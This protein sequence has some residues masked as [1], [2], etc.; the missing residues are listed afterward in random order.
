M[1]DR[2]PR[3]D[4]KIFGDIP[5]VLVGKMWK[6]RLE[7]RMDGVHAMMEHGIHSSSTEGAYSVV[8]SAGYKDDKDSGITFTY[9]GSGGKSSEDEPASRSNISGPQCSDQTVENRSNKALLI[10]VKTRRAVRVVRGPNPNSPWAPVKGYRY[11]GL[12]LV[13][14][15]IE[16]IGE[17]GFV[18]I[19][20]KFRRIEGQPPLSGS[21]KKDRQDRM[22]K[23][24]KK[25]AR[26]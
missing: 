13:D 20:F 18:V 19:K 25:T 14:E 21:N 6:T 15:K 22:L 2:T 16:D 17:D 11:D 1:S 5:G 7:C 10:S 3:H 12:Y 8:L 9:T 26:S 23:M 4:G 24:G